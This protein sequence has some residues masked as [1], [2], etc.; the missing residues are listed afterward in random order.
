ME[1]QRDAVHAVTQ[2]RGLRAVV[3]HMAQ[4]P[5]G[6]AGFLGKLRH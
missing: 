4:V 2:A 6:I 1:L 5:A 3:E